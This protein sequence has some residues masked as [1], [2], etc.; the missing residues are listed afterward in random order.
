MNKL[1]THRDI[2]KRKKILRDIYTN[3]YKQILDD[4]APGDGITLELGAGSGNFKEFKPDVISSDIEPCRWLDIAFDAHLMP[5][6]DES[7]RNI[8]MID[9]LHHLAQPVRFLEEASHV[10]EPGG[11]IVII[12]PFPSPFSLPV[13][14][15]FHPEPFDMSTDY[16]GP[17]HAPSESP[18]FFTDLNKTKDPWDANQ[19]AAYLLFYKQAQK[20]REFFGDRFQVIKRKRMS[21]ILY[22]ASGGFENKSLIP[23]SIV[24]VFRGLEF[25]LTPL[26]PLLAFRCY[27]VLEKARDNGPTRISLK[28]D[29]LR[30]RIIEAVTTRK[31]APSGAALN[32]LHE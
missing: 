16:F 15:K 17:V 7:V 9:V 20:F 11:R 24:P 26:R 18:A 19:A 4:L 30:E 23:D 14:R 22:P 31:T 10:L 27:V 21:C 2:W 12:E 25:L 6:L 32:S 1:E 8:V 29:T 3:W 5:F 13:Y 28:T